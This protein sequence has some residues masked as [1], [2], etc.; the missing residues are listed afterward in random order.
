LQISLSHELTRLFP[1]D[2]DGT[3]T[4]LDLV[5]RAAIAP[6]KDDRDYA[7]RNVERY[8]LGCAIKEADLLIRDFRRWRM[9]RRLTFRRNSRSA[10]TLTAMKLARAVFVYRI[11]ILADTR[12]D[13]TNSPAAQDGVSDPAER[14]ERGRARCGLRLNL[15]AKK[16]AT[17]VRQLRRRSSRD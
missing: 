9:R 12:E 6:T 3:L 8:L 4:L 5:T 2:Q 16:H 7:L 14:R 17:G 11:G 13:G 1:E 15:P 10:L